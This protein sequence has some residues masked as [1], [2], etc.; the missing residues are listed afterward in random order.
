MRL[1]TVYAENLKYSGRTDNIYE[2]EL[3]KDS[4]L[5]IRCQDALSVLMEPQYQPIIVVHSVTEDITYTVLKLWF[6]N[7]Y[8][9][10]VIVVFLLSAD[11]YFVESSDF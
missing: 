10:D 3:L 5:E 4:A 7:K 2:E 1:N 6:T 9:E 11:S 8:N